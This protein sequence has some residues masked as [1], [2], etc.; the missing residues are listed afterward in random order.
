MPRFFFHL[1]TDSARY[2]DDSG[3]VLASSGE[4]LPHAAAIAKVLS[5]YNLMQI[6]LG[7]QPQ[8]DDYLEVEDQDSKF[9][10]TLP[11]V[12]L[13]KGIAEEDAREKALMDGPIDLTEHRLARTY[14]RASA[15]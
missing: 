4:V 9:L 11:F 12:R 13:L 5:K 3:T 1:V 15:A 6:N 10:I 7:R 14:L 8:P 2:Q